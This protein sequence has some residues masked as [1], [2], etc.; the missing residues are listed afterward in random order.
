MEMF[1][2]LNVTSSSSRKMKIQ[3][4]THLTL[5]PTQTPSETWVERDLAR[6][7]DHSWELWIEMSGEKLER[8]TATHRRGLSSDFRQPRDLTL[9]KRLLLVKYVRAERFFYVEEC[10]FEVSGII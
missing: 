7:R 8:P 2:Q 1:S 6:R 4:S 10:S 3:L 5:T 9:S